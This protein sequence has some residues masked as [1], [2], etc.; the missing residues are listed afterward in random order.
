MKLDVAGEQLELSAERAL[1]RPATRQLL[2]ADPHFGKAEVFR[3]RGIPVPEGTTDENLAR[4]DALIARY[5]PR[6]IVFLGDFLHARV[7]EVFASL[8]AW[9]RRH[10]A[11]A[12]TLILGN[13][14]AR[15][16]AVPAELELEI[17]AVEEVDAPFV[18]RHT[19]DGS[20]HGFTLAGHLHPAYRLR[21][22]ARDTLRLPCFWLTRAALVLPAFGEFTGCMDIERRPG[23]RVFVVAADRVVEAPEH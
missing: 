4:L 12:M 1:Y 13:H 11:L 5:E 20:P 14:D 18:Y 10:A 8:I 19:P 22:R 2:V 9:R 21:G 3:T 7:S 16:G 23:D 15:A 17:A 6:E